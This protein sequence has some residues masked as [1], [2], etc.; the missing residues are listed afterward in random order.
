MDVLNPLAFWFAL[1]A[2]P[3]VLLY[4]L[5]LRRRAQ[6]V[7]STLLWRRA[8][9]DREA[10]TLWQRLRRN[11]LLFLQL[12]TLAFLIFALA[13][14]YLQAP[15]GPSRQVI[16]LLDASASM[17][18]TDVRP[19][20]FEAARAQVRALIETLGGEDRMTLIAVDGTPRALS[21]LTNDKVQLRAA[22][23]ALRPTLSAANW[24]AA[25]ALAAAV[26]AGGEEST[27]FVFSDGANADDL[28]LLP[29]AA[30]FI[31][32]GE[33]GDNLALS[34]LA[35]RRARDGLAALVRVTNH[36]LRDEQALVAVRAEE[37]LIDARTI[38]VPAGSAVE[39][40]IRDI[41]PDARWVQAG[42][43]KARYNLLAADD[44]A[45]AINAANVARRALLVT[46]GNLFLEQALAALP[47]LRTTRVAAPLPAVEGY[48]LYVLD[49]V[50]ATLPAG[51]NALLIGAQ[52]VFTPTAIFS[53]T[54]YVRSAPHPI[55]RDLDWRMVSV[56]DAYRLAAPDWLRP[57][58]EGQGGP[59]VLA[60]ESADGAFGRVVA[61]AF[62]LRRSDLPLQ[63]AFPILIANSVAWLA[64]PQGLDIPLSVQPGEVVALPA[65]ARVTLP[66]GET[67]TLGI[68]GFAQTE[69][70]GVYAFEAGQVQGAFAVNF[71]NVAESRIAP[72]PN[73]T[74]GQSSPASAA[75]AQVAQ[76]EL[77]HILAALAL[78]LLAIE[79]W[80]YQRGLPT[81]GRHN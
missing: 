3:I 10:N 45:Y 81:L 57:V 27:T 34:T 39:W 46:P 21:A 58:V 73:L 9:L 40:T 78:A 67:V 61:L 72:N 60:G 52:G 37:A 64:P 12:A 5:R 66:S 8:I 20:R 6:P 11:V 42:I 16:V 19:S 2:I 49:G 56:R 63:I 62:D 35:L 59:L 43:E 23:D 25:V 33:S 71:F 28:A 80:V 32:V 24:G 77:W 14:P 53:D 38:D 41:P 4:L 50:S 26:G 30:R 7:S 74:A 68:Q 17:Q 48:D 36:G 22:L 47:G 65:G 13:R 76:R 1:L 44:I 29:G 18:A 69:Q 79:W 15:G 75:E 31:P 54:A 55:A 70:P 51:A